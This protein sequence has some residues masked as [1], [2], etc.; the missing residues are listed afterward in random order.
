MPIYVF[1]GG[2]LGALSRF[3]VGRLCTFFG[4][5]FTSI[6]TIFVNMI[7]CFFIG[8]LFAVFKNNNY[9]SFLNAFFITGF[10]GGF[11]T[12]STFAL[13]SLQYMNDGDFFAFISYTLLQVVIGIFFVWCGMRLGNIV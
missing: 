12:F 2:G 4:F 6:S 8:I 1:L 3:F 9:P 5:T 11:T 10:L 7:G 13:E